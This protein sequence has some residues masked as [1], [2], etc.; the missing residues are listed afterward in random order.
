M[1]WFA[2]QI[3]RHRKMVIVFFLIA[4]IGSVALFLGVVVNYNMV[5]YLPPDAQSTTA[6]RI[7][8]SEFDTAMPNASVMVEGLSVMEA[9]AYKER[10]KA[11]PGVSQVSWLDDMVD[12]KQP[13]AMYEKETVE[14]YYKD[15]TALFSITIDEGMEREAVDAIRQ[16]IGPENAL[17]GEAPDTA[18]L[19]NT[20]VN[21]VLN[22]II[23]LLPIVMVILF[24]TTTSWIEP[25]LLLATIG[26]SVVLN[27]GTNFIFGQVSFMTNAVSPILQMA[28]SLD[29]AIFILH[30]F[31][32]HRTQTTDVNEAMRLTIKASFTTVSASAL[33]TLFGFLALIFMNFR[34][35]ADLGLS[36]AKGIVLSF[37]CSVIF[38]PALTLSCYKALDRTQH[39]SFLSSSKNIYRFFSKL[40]IPALIIVALVIVPAFLGQQQTEFTYATIDEKSD[41]K[42][43]ALKIEEVFGSSTV[44]AILVPRGDVVKEQSFSQALAKL[45]HV[46]GVVSYANAV[47]TTIPPE[48]LEGD[49]VSQFYSENYARI[50]AYTDTPDEGAAAFSTVESIQ[51]TAKAYYGEEAYSLGRSANLYDMKTL[52]AKDNVMVNM[53]AVIAIF[54]VLLFSLRSLS[55]PFILLITIETGI[56]VNLSIPYFMGSA[57]NFM[58]Y[59]VLSTVQLGATV[60]YAILFTDHYQNQRKQLPKKAALHNAMGDSFQSILVSASI[61]SI[62]GFVLALTSSNPAIADIGMLLGRGTLLSVFMVVCF[63]P[64]MLSLFDGLIGKTTYKANFLSKQRPTDGQDI[65]NGGKP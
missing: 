64:A 27:M 46:T 14:S 42:L 65:S 61:L 23:I 16:M 39:R 7:M 12:I 15:N 47:G 6:L 17:G 25:L 52:V 30:S 58:G 44:V 13:L 18:D 53:V 2:G 45:D 38:L 1:D 8:E 59:L 29:Y 33:T 56:W 26:I 4:T 54:L 24:I 50:I 9:V 41:G 55:L 5:D 28:V 10:L 35:G 21:E 3:V 49:I 63:L 22:A 36:L 48:Y 31:R 40:A 57:I 32:S 60:D 11:V 51:A 20:T 43:D 19:Q 34:I 62:A 37:L